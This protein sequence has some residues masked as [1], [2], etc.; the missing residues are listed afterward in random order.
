MGEVGVRS[1]VRRVVRVEEFHLE[2]V[3]RGDAQGRAAGRGAGHLWKHAVV[4]GDGGSGKKKARASAKRKKASASGNVA[5][6]KRASR[7]PKVRVFELELY[8]V[9]SI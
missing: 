4:C 3:G 9:C 1:W 7:R 8:E 5:I 6:S 2:H